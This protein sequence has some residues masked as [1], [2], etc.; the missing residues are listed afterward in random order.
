MQRL[1]YHTDETL[2][3]IK[4]MKHL[5]IILGLIFISIDTFS[6]SKPIDKVFLLL[7]DGLINNLTL[8]DR[9][10]LLEKKKFYPSD[11]TEE[12]VE[13]YEL[14]YTDKYDDR[15]SLRSYF[16]TGQT[17]YGITELRIFLR[18]N[19]DTVVILSSYGGTNGLAEQSNLYTFLLKNP[20][21]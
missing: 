14:S 1:R 20:N 21:S 9:Q 19:G 2:A 13:I 18:T 15:L 4:K 8:K 5:L 3:V 16:E 6:Q 7:P 11:N 12:S 17:L 10:T